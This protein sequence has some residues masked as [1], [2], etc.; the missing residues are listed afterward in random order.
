MKDINH[1]LTRHLR[2]KVRA[3]STIKEIAQQL[4]AIDRGL[5]LGFLWDVGCLSMD[6]VSRLLDSLKAAKLLQ[7]TLVVVQIGHESADDFGVCHMNR[8]VGQQLWRPTVV[9]VS[10]GQAAPQLAD[11][12]VVAV[13]NGYTSLLESRLEII[14]SQH[15]ARRTN[16]PIVVW[17]IGPSACRTSAYGLFIGYPVVYWYD[18]ERTQ[19]NCL[20][21]VPLTVFQASSNEQTNTLFNPFVSFSVPNVLLNE[22]AVNEAITVWTESMA[23]AGLKCVTFCKVFSNVIM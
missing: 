3:R 5:K 11:E 12:R 1:Y 19:D 10:A 2:A 14:R 6:E 15:T 18:T 16:T 13:C 17:P 4:Y 7:D 21:H 22:Q 23:R 20:A 9:D 8:F